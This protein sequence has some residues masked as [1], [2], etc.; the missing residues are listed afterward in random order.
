VPKLR[1]HIR[2][3]MS[4]RAPA[5]PPVMRPLRSLL[6]I[7]QKPEPEISAFPCVDPIETAAAKLSALAWRV[8]ARDR[9]RSDDDPTIVRHLHDLAALERHVVSASSCGELVRAAA[10]ADI[11]GGGTSTLPGNPAVIFADMQRR[12]ETDPLWAREYEDFVRAISFAGPDEEI[13]FD[14]ALHAVRRLIGG[15]GGST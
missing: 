8:R 2:I 10:A 1:P 15:V 7:A 4:F 6:A 5:L 11:G 12:L 14:R 9:T 13:G 3:E